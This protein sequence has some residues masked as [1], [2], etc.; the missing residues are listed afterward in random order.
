MLPEFHMRACIN[1]LQTVLEIETGRTLPIS[2]YEVIVTVIT[3]PQKSPYSKEN[4][5]PNPLMYIDGKIV[6]KLAANQIQKHI[7]V[8]IHQDKDG[9]IP[10]MQ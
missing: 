2:S 5:R 8:I 1:T 7:K 9:F 3:K 4:I 10:A 6:N